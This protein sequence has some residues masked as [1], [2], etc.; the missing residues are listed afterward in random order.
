[1]GKR[2]THSNWGGRRE[3]AGR[4]PTGD[5]PKAVK[6]FSL[7]AE[8]VAVLERKVPESMSASQWIERLILDA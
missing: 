5:T 3:G 8:A 1:M 4:K 6:S 7:S 2:E